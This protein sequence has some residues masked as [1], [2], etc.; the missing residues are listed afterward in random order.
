[1]TYIEELISSFVANCRRQLEEAEEELKSSPWGHLTRAKNNGKVRYYQSDFSKGSTKRITVNDLDTIKTLLRKEYLREKADILKKQYQV[2]KTAL[3]QL[4]MTDDKA[5]L[6]RI[7]EKRLSVAGP[8]RLPDSIF[9]VR[10]PEA[11]SELA[12]HVRFGTV[13]SKESW[14]N[15]PFQQSD[16]KPEAKRFQTSFGLKV[17]SKSELIIAE[18]LRSLGIPF[19]YEAVVQVGNAA[20]APDFTILRPDGSTVYW[21]HWGLV[22][23]LSYYDR[24]LTKLRAYYSAGIVPWN[25]LIISYDDE[26][27]VIDAA[28]VL[29]L[30]NTRILQDR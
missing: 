29:Y 11:D 26:S 25:N 8:E 15:E 12:D 3:E 17:R 1:M 19:R 9:G 6:D 23:N 21:E 5:L 2:L 13:A 18:L 4:P 7:L 24:Q 28:K 14:M 20:Y 27:G 22:S 30:I 10:V 16:F